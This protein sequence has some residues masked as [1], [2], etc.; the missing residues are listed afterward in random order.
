MLIFDRNIQFPVY[1]QASTSHSV[2]TPNDSIR[3]LKCS[4]GSDALH[5]D[6]ISISIKIIDADM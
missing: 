1:F 3:K 6:A 5:G 4:G 2:L